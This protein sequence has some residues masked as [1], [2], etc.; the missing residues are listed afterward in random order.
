MFG[1]ETVIPFCVSMATTDEPPDPAFCIARKRA[2]AVGLVSAF[3]TA[4]VVTGISVAVETDAELFLITLKLTEG[5]VDV[6]VHMADPRWP[7]KH[8]ANK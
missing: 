8:D 6:K 3:G 1:I 7:R 5:S 4:V 2:R